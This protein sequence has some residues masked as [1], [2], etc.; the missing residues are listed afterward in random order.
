MS[1][2]DV[3]TVNNAMDQAGITSDS[4]PF[5]PPADAQAQ[6]QARPSS[7][8]L[9]SYPADFYWTWHEPH[10]RYYT[11]LLSEGSDYGTW[12]TV[13][14]HA[15]DITWISHQRMSNWDSWHWT[16]RQGPSEWTTASG[17]LP[18]DEIQS[19]H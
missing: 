15:S 11:W 3:A 7:S 18:S 5:Q 6:P 10:R 1:A 2:P 4:D 17:P 14:F 9:M 12:W 8:N 13:W 16:H 19:L